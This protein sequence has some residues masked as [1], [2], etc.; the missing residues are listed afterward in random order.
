MIQDNHTDFGIIVKLMK[1]GGSKLKSVSMEDL[2]S[3]YVMV[4]YKCITVSEHEN[5]TLYEID[6]NSESNR[7]ALKEINGRCC[8]PLSHDTLVKEGGVVTYSLKKADMQDL[9]IKLSDL[10]RKEH[11]PGAP[12]NDGTVKCHHCDTRLKLKSLK[13][14]VAQ[15][16][17][18]KTLSDGQ[19]EATCGFCGLNSVVFLTLS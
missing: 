5:G 14:H 10:N 13:I 15:H 16:I 2:S 18:N 11:N 12:S 8:F 17:L 7:G 3:G 4:V 1:I 9:G 6:V 19:T